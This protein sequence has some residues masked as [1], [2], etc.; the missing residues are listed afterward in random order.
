MCKKG[1]RTGRE[2]T[3]VEKEEREVYINNL[4]SLTTVCANKYKC[5]THKIYQY[6]WSIQC[7]QTKYIIIMLCT[8]NN[9]C[10]L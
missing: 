7:P 3:G 10:L 1:M 2:G 8:F 9:L 6:M 5:S 4:F